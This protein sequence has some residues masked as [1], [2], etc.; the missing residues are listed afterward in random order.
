M[1]MRATFTLPPSAIR[2]GRTSS[3]TVSTFAAVSSS[4][5]AVDDGAGAA[6]T[7][8]AGSTPA[9]NGL[10]TGAASVPAAASL[11]CCSNGAHTSQ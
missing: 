2:Y 3:S 5:V 8:G 6:A 10:C 7:V 11:L 9:T 1:S 4:P